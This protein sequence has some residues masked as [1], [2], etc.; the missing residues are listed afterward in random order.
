MN[1]K[2][3]AELKKSLLTEL[4]GTVLNYL[5]ESKNDMLRLTD[6]VLEICHRTDEL[7]DFKGKTVV[8]QV[9][10]KKEVGVLQNEVEA[11]KA[12]LSKTNTSLDTIS[13]KLEKLQSIPVA[14]DPKE[15]QQCGDGDGND[16]SSNNNNNSNDGCSSNNNN[17]NGNNN[18]NNNNKTKQPENNWL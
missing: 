15:K 10:L 8:H 4:N 2:E 1:K 9:A 7:D 17:N 5:R 11:M 12:M 14:D 13:K 16:A 6:Q 3:F 18:N